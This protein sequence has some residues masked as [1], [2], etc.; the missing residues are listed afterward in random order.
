MNF[1][2]SHSYVHVTLF[3]LTYMLLQMANLWAALMATNEQILHLLSNHCGYYAMHLLHKWLIHDM[4]CFIS[5]LLHPCYC[6][7]INYHDVPY[8]W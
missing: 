8:E 6:D 4:D 3:G 2:I 5:E 7:I 1:D